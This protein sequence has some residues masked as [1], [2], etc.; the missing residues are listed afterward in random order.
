MIYNTPGEME[1]VIGKETDDSFFKI[2]DDGLEDFINR[3]NKIME[4]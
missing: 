1:A 2:Q 4:I 3:S